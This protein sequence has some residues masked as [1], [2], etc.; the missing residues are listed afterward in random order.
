MLTAW[1]HKH[2]GKTP[3]FPGQI[4][5]QKAVVLKTVVIFILVLSMLLLSIR[6]LNNISQ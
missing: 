1:R 6:V 2:V 4:L 5:S 3:Y